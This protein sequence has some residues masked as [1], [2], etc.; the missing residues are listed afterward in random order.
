MLD[1]ILN[2]SITQHILHTNKKTM[3]LSPEEFYFRDTGYPRC[4]IGGEV[5]KVFEYYRSV[6]IEGQ[7]K[8]GYPTDVYLKPTAGPDIHHKFCYGRRMDIL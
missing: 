3:Y 5:P 8:T 4:K 1:Y 2:A 6:H 7:S